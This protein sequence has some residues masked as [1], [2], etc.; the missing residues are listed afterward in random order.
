LATLLLLPGLAGCAGHPP[1]RHHA[2]GDLP[3]PGG[4]SYR[5][6]EPPAGVADGPLPVVYFLHDIFGGDA[7]LW[8]HGVAPRLVARMASGDLPPFLLVAPAGDRGFWSDYHDG[9]RRYETW[10]AE[11]LPREI[12]ARYPVLPGP[13]G[14]GLAGISM[15]GYGAFK[16]ALRHPD[17]VGAAASLS[18]MVPPL[19]WK[20]LEEANLVARR[21]LAKVFGG[22]RTDNSLREGDLYR[23]LPRLYELPRAQR[24]RL[25][26]RVGNEDGYR[27][28]EAADLF[29]LVAADHGV[30]VELVLEPGRHGWSYWSRTVE[31]TIAWTVHALHQRA[32]Q[33]GIAAPAGVPVAATGSPR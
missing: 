14:R 17:Q 1:P 18:G 11:E 15:G 16:Q 4:G 10:L 31:E 6:L 27:L 28:D 33:D 19:E 29:Q 20:T 32:R 30:Q 26:L 2:T 25:L 23:M 24:P 3:R 21:L 22:E 7:V 5:V 8:R 13:A 12:A 9:S